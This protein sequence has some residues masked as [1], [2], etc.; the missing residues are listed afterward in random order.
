MNKEHLKQVRDALEDKLQVINY[1]RYVHTN[2]YEVNWI[3]TEIK[4]KEALEIIDLEIAKPDVD[5]WYTIDTAPKDGTFYLAS[6]VNKTWVENY[7]EGYCEGVWY[8]DDSLKYW[9]GGA[10]M[11]YRIATQWTHLPKSKG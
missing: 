11:D 5:V 1:I 7:P 2:E 6:N 10:H 3:C 9:R 4:I 8:W